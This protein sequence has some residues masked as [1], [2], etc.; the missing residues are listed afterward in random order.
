M[1][2][3]TCIDVVGAKLFLLPVPGSLDMIMMAQ[4]IGITAAAAMT[5]R[6][7]RHVSVDFFVMLLPKRLRAAIEV[8]VQALCLALFVIIAW[9][10]FDHGYHLQTGHEQTPTAGIPMAPF[11]YLAALATVP[12]CVVFLQQLLSAILGVIQK[13]E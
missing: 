12:V 10:L 13:N 9:R 2:V 4:V 7:D 3:V 11:G 5:L 8:V 6:Q 1:V